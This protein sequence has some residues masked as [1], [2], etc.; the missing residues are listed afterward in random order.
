MNY[1]ILA[2]NNGGR[3]SLLNQQ[4]RRSAS[5][6]TVTNGGGATDSL[7]YHQLARPGT[8]RTWL[9]CG[10]AGVVGHGTIYGGSVDELP[11]GGGGYGSVINM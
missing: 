7:P 3:Q 6:A 8:S 11:L 4:Q 10:G 1:N 9:S 2:K 5:R